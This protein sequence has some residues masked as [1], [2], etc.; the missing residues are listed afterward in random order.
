MR[1]SQKNL[2]LPH[3]EPRSMFPTRARRGAASLRALA[4]LGVSLGLL[5]RPGLTAQDKA[6][7]VKDGWDGPWSVV[8]LVMG[9]KPAPE[10]MVKLLQFTFRG[11]KLTLSALGKTKE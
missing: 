11:E 6:G 8:S 5:A 10:E 2:V 9:G 7:T 4:A 1:R 3:K